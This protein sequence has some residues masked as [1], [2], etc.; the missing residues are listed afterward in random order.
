MELSFHLGRKPG[1]HEGIR[2]VGSTLVQQ[3]CEGL[4]SVT[5]AC[6]HRTQALSFFERSKIFTL[7]VL[8]ERY[9]VGIVIADDRGN[10]C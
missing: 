10:H 5:V 9:L 8:D 2:D 7:E 4:M 6:H 1:E 3:L